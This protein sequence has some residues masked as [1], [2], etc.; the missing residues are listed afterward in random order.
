MT[1]LELALDVG[2][3]QAEMVKT[4]ISGENQ[5]YE[6]RIKQLDLLYDLI[7]DNT[8]KIREAVCIDLGRNPTEAIVMETSVVKTEIG[9]AKRN[10][11]RWMKPQYVPSAAVIVPGFSKH[12]AR[13]LNPPGV[14]IIGPFNYP[15]GLILRPLV[16]VLAAGNPAVIKPS[17]LCPNTSTLMKELMEKYFDAG[18]VQVVLG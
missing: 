18:V 17:E 14:L 9:F 10:L 7:V 12:V 1:K 11:R 3:V 8:E 4:H 6:W 16:G 2:K 13:P 15:V 5:T